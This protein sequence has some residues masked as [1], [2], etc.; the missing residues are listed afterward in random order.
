MV[1]R[2]VEYCLNVIPYTF[3]LLQ[4]NMEFSLVNYI[5]VECQDIFD[6]GTQ[7]IVNN[8]FRVEVQH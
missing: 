3:R 4:Y 8:V 5:C 6:R 7:N 1:G 2:A